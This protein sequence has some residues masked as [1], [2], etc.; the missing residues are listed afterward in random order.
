M[1]NSV[2][3]LI[4]EMEGELRNLES[5]VKTLS[6]EINPHPDDV[7]LCDKLSTKIQCYRKFVT[8]LNKL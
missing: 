1:E 2:K 5:E 4:L 7:I 6:C 3:K 8:K